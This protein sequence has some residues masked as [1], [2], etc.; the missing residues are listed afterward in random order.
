MNEWENSLYIFTFN[1]VAW[2]VPCVLASAFYFKVVMAVYNSVASK[3]QMDTS[4][5]SY[6]IKLSTASNPM[7]A[8]NNSAANEN[9]GTKP[10][11][12]SEAYIQRLRKSVTYKKTS[13]EYERRKLQTV[14]LTLTIVACNFLL[15]APFCIVNVVKPLGISPFS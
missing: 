15:W 1:I 12:S 5:K 2:L 13:N 6:S 7:I 4:K 11:E 8:S 10:K 9:N 3:P 14:K